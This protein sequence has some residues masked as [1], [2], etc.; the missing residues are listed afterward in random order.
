MQLQGRSLPISGLRTVGEE[1]T[2]LIVSNNYSL[3]GALAI[4]LMSPIPEGDDDHR[5]HPPSKH[6]RV[7]MDITGQYN[8]THCFGGK[9][10]GTLNS[11]HCFGGKRGGILNS[12]HFLAGREGRGKTAKKS[13]RRVR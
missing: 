10:G 8:S 2:T 9:R 12:T 1:E 7:L 11:M 3:V 6:L 5:H 13:D 4:Y